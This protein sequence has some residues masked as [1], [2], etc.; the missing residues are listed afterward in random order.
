MTRPPLN[1]FLALCVLLIVPEALAAAPE[2]RDSNK[3]G[4]P[5]TWIQYGS[6]GQASLI[7]DD[8]DHHDGKPHHWRFFS[9]G[10]VSKREWDRNFDGKVDLRI[11]ERHGHL[12]QKDYDDNFDGRFEKTEKLPG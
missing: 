3:D 2:T 12:V 9:H 8:G 5:D 7:A 10:E 11:F 1:L 4:R 6:S